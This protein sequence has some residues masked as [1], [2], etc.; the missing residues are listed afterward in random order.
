MWVE[1]NSKFKRY[2]YH[3]ARVLHL[4][5]PYLSQ[6]EPLNNIMKLRINNRSILFKNWTCGTQGQQH[7][8]VSEHNNTYY[9]PSPAHLKMQ[10]FIAF[11]LFLLLLTLCFSA[12]E[13]ANWNWN[14][15]LKFSMY[16]PDSAF[17][18]LRT[19][20]TPHFPHSALSTPRTFHTPHFPD[21][22]LSTLRTFHTPHYAFSIEPC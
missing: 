3:S 5:S 18:T 13:M 6:G 9:N 4:K 19:F 20:Y 21:P 11:F 2:Q 15:K 12:F 22:A 10:C 14:G 8:G 1:A 17:S 16:F 7:R